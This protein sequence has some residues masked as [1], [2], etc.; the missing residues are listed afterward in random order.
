MPGER[1]SGVRDEYLIRHELGLSGSGNI[2]TNGQRDLHTHIHVDVC[3][4]SPF[5]AVEWLF[6]CSQQDQRSEVSRP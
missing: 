4:L 1:A 6:L 3:P 5:F 2:G